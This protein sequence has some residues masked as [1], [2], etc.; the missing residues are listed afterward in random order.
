M[1][2]DIDALQR[3]LAELETRDLEHA[4]AAKVKDALYRIAEAASSVEDLRAFYATVH[5]I[6]A[7]LMYAEN[8][9]IALYDEQRQAINYPY[10]VDPVDTDIP[11]PSV[12]DPIGTGQ[13]TGVTAYALRTGKP[14]LIDAA[15]HHEL[16]ARGEVETLGVVAEG[17]WLGAPL[18]AEGRTLGVIVVQSY[19]SDQLH[20]EADK[21]L[22]AFVGQH[23][24]SALSR[25]RAIE[26]TRQ[27]NAE[28]ALINEIG[29][30]LAKQLDFAAIIE[31]V[32][33]RVRAIF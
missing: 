3:R 31:L 26:E 13:A 29:S 2:A 27:R 1:T 30:A 21:D 32:G 14:Q 8:C 15:A 33:E 17:S 22:L 25:A 23:I 19:T 18:V 16:V 20:T 4:R 12:W 7:D 5:G 6:V 10:F 24:G 28:L 11:D 9:Y